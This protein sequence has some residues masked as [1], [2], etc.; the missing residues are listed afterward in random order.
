MARTPS[1]PEPDYG[2]QSIHSSD[3]FFID[4]PMNNQDVSQN[5]SPISNQLYPYHQQAF[6]HYSPPLPDPIRPYP[7]PSFYPSYVHRAAPPLPPKPAPIAPIAPTFGYSP[8]QSR[9]PQPSHI[10]PQLPPQ[11]VEEEE[12]S[13]IDESSTELAM[14]L[15]LSQSESAERQKLEEQLLDQEEQDLARALAESM[16]MLSAENNTNPFFIPASQVASSSRIT[17]HDTRTETSP[18]RPPVGLP[19]QDVPHKVDI[20]YPAD[21]TNPFADIRRYDKW[22]IPDNSQEEPPSI[23]TRAESSSPPKRFSYSGLSFPI[24]ELAN[25]TTENARSV[26]RSSSFSSVSSLPYTRPDPPTRSNTLDE[27]DSLPKYSQAG[28]TQFTPQDAPVAGPSTIPTNVDAVQV[29]ETMDTVLVFDDEAYARQLEAEEQELARQYVEEKSRPPDMQ[30]DQPSGESLPQYTSNSPQQS[31]WQRIEMVPAR[32]VVP[33]Q[34]MSSTS[35][36]SRPT[37]TQPHH[38]TF[39]GAQLRPQEYSSRPISSLPEAGPSASFYPSPIHRP[40]SDS[41]TRSDASH[42]SSGHSSTGPQTAHPERLNHIQQ[43]PPQSISERRPSYSAVPQADNRVPGPVQHAP[44]PGA[45]N[46]N[47]FL[48]R[49]LLLGV[50]TS[51]HS[52]FP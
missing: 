19:A 25:E 28:A 3:L 4:N 26:S 7:Q 43:Q 39:G 44:T 16:S 40:H 48:D 23:G 35:G 11:E 2:P 34:P 13:P 29:A 1:K 24:P 45:L 31:N 46:A 15:A 27:T 36:A 12:V 17:T 18:Q 41:D 47:H 33:S 6:H 10:P 5:N 50:C 8:S 52:K 38:P 20:V 14:A 51:F 30:G 37:P 9:F 49:E 22:R 21:P 42:Q 32:L